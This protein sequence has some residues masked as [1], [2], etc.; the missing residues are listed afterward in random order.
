MSKR[1]NV[2]PEE[3]EKRLNDVRLKIG[4]DIARVGFTMI[5]V[6]SDGTH[7]PFTYT[8]GLTAQGYP[9]MIMM[10]L[11]SEHVAPV[12][13]QYYESL[14]NGGSEI[15]GRNEEYFNLPAYIIEAD[16]EL[17]KEYATQAEQW[18]EDY[19]L[20]PRYIQWV[21]TDREGHFPWEKTF[22]LQFSHYQKI[23]G[24]APE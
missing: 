23:M 15:R 9:E 24:K 2:T 4:A 7:P 22:D 3:L 19:G 1:Q 6:M 8:I 16:R 17:V 13:N 10:G 11:N 12:F 20:T 5:G 14:K 21:W 18:A